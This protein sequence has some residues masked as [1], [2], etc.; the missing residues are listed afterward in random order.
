MNIR[1][2]R[3][4]DY[5]GILELY[6]ELDEL[7]QSNHS[8]LFR[9]P[10]GASRPLDYIADLVNAHDKALFI[11]EEN[12][13]I[14][15]L[16]ECLVMRSPNFPVIKRREWVQLD[17]IAVKQDYQHKNIGSS[18]LKE[19]IQWA[20]SKNIERIELK[21]YSFNTNALEFY[22]R[23]DFK[24]LARTMYLNLEEK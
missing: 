17:S 19:V 14:M 4:D 6:A 13:E 22:S 15:G 24:D 23:N 10:E 8:E 20:E 5:A 3:L 12:S 7:H 1:K 18:L 11:A 2:A 21:V 16:A 9:P